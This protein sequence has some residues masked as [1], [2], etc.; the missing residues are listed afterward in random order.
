MFGRNIPK[1]VT[2][3]L[4][5]GRRIDCQ[6]L[7]GERKVTQLLEMAE[8]FSLLE[9][10]LLLFTYCGGGNF[11]VVIFDNARVEK[12]LYV[13]E[14]VSETTEADNINHEGAKLEDS[15]ANLESDV[16]MNEADLENINADEVVDME[17]N[18]PE[19]AFSSVMTKCNIGNTS[20]GAV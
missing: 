1:S 15:I 8:L 18:D 3:C 6:Y 7:H 20:H 11:D 13:Y 14:N 2:L 16:E 12:E 19:M 5:N 17:I 4:S 10:D 9:N